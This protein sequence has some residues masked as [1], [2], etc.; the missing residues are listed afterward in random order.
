MKIMVWMVALLFCP[1]AKQVAD[2]GSRTVFAHAR[3]ARIHGGWPSY[4][5]LIHDPSG[6]TQTGL[7]AKPGCWETGVRHISLNIEIVYHR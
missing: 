1:S 7:V 4:I 6:Y 5:L 2:Q 3:S